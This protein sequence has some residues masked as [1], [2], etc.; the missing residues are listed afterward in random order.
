[1]AKHIKTEGS[2][3]PE[4]SEQTTERS[5]YGERSALSGGEAEIN[6]QFDGQL[7]WAEV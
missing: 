5:L 4:P 7:R 3:A 1:M 2:F 6:E